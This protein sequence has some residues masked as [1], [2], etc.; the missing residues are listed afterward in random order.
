MTLLALTLISLSQVPIEH[1]PD[2]AA[3]KAAVLEARAKRPTDSA[4]LLTLEQ[5]KVDDSLADDLKKFDWYQ[6]GSWSY[7]EKSFS[8]S[9]LAPE[10]FQYDVRRYLGDGSELSYSFVVN[11]LDASKAEFTHTNFATPNP[12]SVAVKK[13]GKD[14]YLEVKVFGEKELQRVRS[15]EHGVLIIDVSYDGKVN[16]KTVK[17]REVRIAMPRVFESTGK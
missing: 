1:Q 15:Y 4:K 16:S 6:A 2:L 7:P 17:F 3:M 11:R 5:P 14:T 8:P 13:V 10:A 9:Y 12:I